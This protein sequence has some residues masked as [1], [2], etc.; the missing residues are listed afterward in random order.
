MDGLALTNKNEELLVTEINEQ[1]QQR[2]VSAEKS[3][4]SSTF[5]PQY[6][7]VLSEQDKKE[8]TDMVLDP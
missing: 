2:M 1:I 8:I 3:E 7:S 5:V 6:D 4:T